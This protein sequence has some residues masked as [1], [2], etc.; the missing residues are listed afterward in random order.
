MVTNTNR[1]VK[2]YQYVLAAGCN[3]AMFTLIGLT[4]QRKLFMGGFDIFADDP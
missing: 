2:I 1:G 3:I 4:S